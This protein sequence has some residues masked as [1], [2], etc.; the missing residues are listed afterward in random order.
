MVTYTQEQEKSTT[1]YEPEKL[2]TKDKYGIFM[3]GNHPIAEIR[4]LADSDQSFCLSRI[5]MQ[6]ALYRFL[7]RSSG[8]S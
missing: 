2:K 1:L 7:L 8:R 6:T 3:N 5:P 4:T